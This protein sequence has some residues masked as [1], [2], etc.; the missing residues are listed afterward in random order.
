MSSVCSGGLRGSSGWLKCAQG[1]SDVLSG[2]QVCP[3][4]AQVA[5]VV[6]S[7]AQGGPR[8]PRTSSG[9][10]NMAQGGSRALR[11]AQRG[12]GAQGDSIGLKWLR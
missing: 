10:R 1:G 7:V 2:A 8:E 6:L 5:Q 9:S 11:M 3:G 12:G 4:V